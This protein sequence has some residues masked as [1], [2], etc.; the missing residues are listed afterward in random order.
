MFHISCGDN[1]LEPRF[2][3]I[4]LGADDLEA[5]LGE[6]QLTRNA[7]HLDSHPACANSPGLQRDV[8]A[9]VANLPGQQRAALALRLRLHLGYA[10]IAASLDCT[11]RE[12]RE[13][14]YEV[15]HALRAHLGDRI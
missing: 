10:E 12:A 14:V 13:T 8:A 3:V 15:L 4:T 2:F 1:V 9:F 6:Q 5:S 11:E 7:S